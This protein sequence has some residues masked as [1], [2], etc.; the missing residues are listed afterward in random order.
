MIRQAGRKGNSAGVIDD[1]FFDLRLLFG[2]HRRSETRIDF[3]KE[4][5]KILRE[6]WEDMS[7]TL[8]IITTKREHSTPE[9]TDVLVNCVFISIIIMKQHLVEVQELRGA[10]IWIILTTN[11]YIELNSRK[12]IL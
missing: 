12:R 9:C 2:L 3:V 6:G 10:K 8:A 1:A 7:I 5:I 11:F 4:V